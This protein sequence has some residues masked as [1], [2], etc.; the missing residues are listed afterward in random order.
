MIKRRKSRR[1]T[2]AQ[3]TQFAKILRTSMTPAERLLW[4]RLRRNATGV[5]FRRQAPLGKFILDFYC[6]KSKLAVEVDGDI[7]VNQTGHDNERSE[8][9]N[10]QKQIRV[11]RVTNKEIIENM[12]GVIM[13]ILQELASAPSLPSPAKKIP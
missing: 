2:T 3:T 9:L 7:H 5:H 10:S 11:L 1:G 4:S 6:A 8:W 13:Y 12:D